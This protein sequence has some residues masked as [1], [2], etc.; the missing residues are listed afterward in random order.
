MSEG[1]KKKGIIGEIKEIF[2]FLTEGEPSPDDE[3]DAREL[4]IG[5]FRELLEDGLIPEQKDQI[6]KIL[7]KLEEWDTLELWFL[8]TSIPSDIEQLLNISS[9]PTIKIQEINEKTPSI[10]K[11]KPQESEF[12]IGE[13][14]DK[15]SQQFKGEIDVL[16][17]TIE[18]L[19]KEI[20][21]KDEAIQE[22]SHKR[23]VQKITPKKN[24]NL[25]PLKIKIP[26]IKKTPFKIEE[27]IEES[28]PPVLPEFPPLKPIVQT[29]RISEQKKKVLT[30]IPSKPIELEK[31][32]INGTLLTPIPIKT[33]E[34]RPKKPEITTTVIEER[35]DKPLISEKKKVT[36]VI[37]E[38]R[39]QTS[40]KGKFDSKPFSVEKPRISSV[41]IEEAETQSI[42]SSGL[43]LFDVLSSV[44]EDIRPKGEP[45]PKPI[46]AEQEREP[47]SKPFIKEPE[48]IK[49]S[50]KAQVV[51]FI[52][53][54]S[55]TEPR[56][57]ETKQKGSDELPNDKDTLYQELIALEGKRYAIEKTFKELENSYNK[58]SIS[59]M[60]YKSSNDEFKDKMKEITAR[61]NTIRRLISSL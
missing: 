32:E 18:N 25:P 49:S 8:E 4:M 48:I 13:I 41:R 30:P 38:E 43:D 12:D 61:I 33:A 53:F 45:K 36:T 42:K 21:K 16:K 37:E 54:N 11:Q 44:G 55:K 47:P 28:I 9:K 2:L 50:E 57:A 10:E 3:I 27:Q 60:Q 1:E 58:G 39:D 46:F 59:D 56:K 20:D 40:N 14:V 17:D 31:R 22:I 6:N 19:K 34:V 26:I 52:D 35:K 15:V 29:H 7:K 24:V 5:K 23:K 51:S